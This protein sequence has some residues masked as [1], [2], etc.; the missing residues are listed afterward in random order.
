[1][2]FGSEVLAASPWRGEFPVLEQEVNGKPLVYL[3]SAASAQ[4]PRVVLD[5]M[6]Y[7]YRM[8]NANVHRGVHALGQRSTEAYD[9]SRE[10]VRAA[11]NASSADEIVF[12]KGCTESINLVAS[13]W[14]QANLGEGD[15]ILATQAEHHA[16]IIPWQLV[17]AR[18]GSKVLPIP[19]FDDGTLDWDAYLQ[20]LRSH[21][22]K[23]VAVKHIC[24]ALGTVY[25]VKEMAAEAHSIGALTLVDGA[26]AVP[27]MPVDVRDIDAD[28]Y[29]V[30]GHKA[31]GPMGVGA[32]YGRKKLLQAMPPYQG[33]G[34]MI[35]TV[36]FEGSTFREP[37]ARFEAG[38]PNVAGVVG[39]A[40]AL[41]WLGSQDRCEISALECS[42]AA[43]ATEDLEAIPGVR[44]LG[45]TSGKA[46]VVSFVADFAHPH[47]LATI[48]D[49]EGVA[50]RAG[51]HCCMPLMHRLKV[52]ATVRASFAMYNGETDKDLLVKA[53]EKARRIFS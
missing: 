13:S 1:M 23:M 22:V 38:T 49:S 43:S 4:K 24:N 29:S 45:K 18:T 12:T 47:D 35:R 42:L 9:G 27:H 34:D 50:V 28:F 39:L 5:T 51:H 48:L 8:D 36:S 3:D 16:N 15:V 41:D 17:A 14:G 2:A 40:A 21:P 20:L 44:V 37:P 30:A 10:A 19:V 25:P 53:V 26:Q 33:G 32:L 11:L 31:F 46:A 7:Y 6:D 52:P